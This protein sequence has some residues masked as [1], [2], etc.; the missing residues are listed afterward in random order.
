MVRA[1]PLY[2]PSNAHFGRLRAGTLGAAPTKNETAPPSEGGRRG[3]SDL[4]GKQQSVTTFD[5]KLT[6]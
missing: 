4:G 6:L 2:Q 5:V 3:G 1:Y